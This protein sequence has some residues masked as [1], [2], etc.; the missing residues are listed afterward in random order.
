[1]NWTVGTFWTIG[2][3]ALD[4]GDRLWSAWTPGTP[5]SAAVPAALIGGGGTGARTHGLMR[6]DPMDWTPGT[7]GRQGMTPDPMD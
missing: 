4:T 3:D 7:P 2:I 5:G 6:H 1:M